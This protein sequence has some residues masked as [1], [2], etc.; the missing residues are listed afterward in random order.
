MKRLAALGLGA[1]AG[2]ITV[3]W[4]RKRRHG[5]DTDSGSPGQSDPDSVDGDDQ[6]SELRRKLDEARERDGQSVGA[7]TVEDDADAAEVAADAPSGESGSV[8]VPNG[9]AV[10]S[11]PGDA[12]DI[13]DRR[14]RVHGKAREAA[15]SM[16]DGDDT[17][18]V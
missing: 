5:R 18:A 13:A 2:L 15:E 12:T 6:A 4:L 7:A 17:G 3:G 9:G 10:S 8:E 16:R 14:A 1:L 11:Q